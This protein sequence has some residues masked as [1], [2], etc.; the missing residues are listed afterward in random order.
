MRLCRALGVALA[1][2]LATGVAR[3]GINDPD[4]EIAK[5]HF[6][7]GS[8][9]YD[10][11]SY[12]EALDEFIAAARVK[13]GPALEYNI[14]RCYDRLEEW[15]NAIKHYELY[16]A[17]TPNAAD[18]DEVHVRMV[19]LK[20]RLDEIHSAVVAPPPETTVL[21]LV[22]DDHV[23]AVRPV[24]E[25]PRRRTAAIVAGVVVGALLV[26]GAVALGVLLGEPHAPAPTKSDLGPWTT[27]R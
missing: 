18:T 14:A 11:K 17:E 2:L 22:M 1:L 20:K 4:I 25:H 9:F 12:R 27:T 23:Q 6:A 13:P 8:A 5:R 24:D 15:A 3:A 7:R 21:P 19:A 16:L 26:G 10:A